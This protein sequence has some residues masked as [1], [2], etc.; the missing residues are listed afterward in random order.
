MAD[1]LMGANDAVS[2]AKV[3]ILSQLSPGGIEE[4]MKTPAGHLEFQH[5]R[6]SVATKIMDKKQFNILYIIE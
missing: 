5:R 1:L 2:P 3:V 4:T 6:K